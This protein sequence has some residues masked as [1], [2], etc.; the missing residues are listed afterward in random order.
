[1][2]KA[3]SVASWNVEHF[4]GDPARIERVIA[5]LGD[6]NTMGMQYPFK[7]SID[8]PIELRKLDASAKKA[9]MRRLTK[10]H[11]A[12]WFN[13]SQSTF[14]PTDIDHVIAADHIGF[15][16][17]TRTGGAEGEVDVRGW[18]A[19]ANPDKWISQYSD[20]GLLYFEIQKG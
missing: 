19:A 6:L 17:L 8:A 11:A 16:T 2:P 18:P 14:P 3:F 5:F 13:G 7:R 12:T 1:M 20:H 4:K 9:V 15:K 10:T